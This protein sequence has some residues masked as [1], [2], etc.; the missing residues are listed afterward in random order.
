MSPS[1]Y[2]RLLLS[3]RRSALFLMCKCVCGKS[4]HRD[5]ISCLT[6][7]ILMEK[8]VME[9]KKCKEEHSKN[10]CEVDYLLNVQEW[11]IVFDI[12]KGWQVELGC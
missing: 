1:Q 9:Y 7:V 5:H 2:Q 6:K 10:F 3:W 12:L 8:H 4:W 11:N